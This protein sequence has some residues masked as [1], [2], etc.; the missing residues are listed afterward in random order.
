MAYSQWEHCC[1]FDVII[2][3]FALHGGS[4]EIS[5]KI[6]YCTAVGRFD[7]VDHAGGHATCSSRNMLLGAIHCRCNC[8]G[9][10][11]LCAGHFFQENLALEEYWHLLME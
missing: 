1:L 11:E 7:V 9:W 2:M 3:Q 10:Y 8:T 5:F 6:W 4:Y